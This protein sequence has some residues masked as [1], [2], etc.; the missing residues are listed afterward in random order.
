M[1]RYTVLQNTMTQEDLLGFV[2]IE[3]DGATPTTEDLTWL[4]EVGAWEEFKAN[5]SKGEESEETSLPEDITEWL[6]KLNMFIA[7]N[8]SA[9][10][11]KTTKKFRKMGER[12][13]TLGLVPCFDKDAHEMEETQMYEKKEEY[14]ENTGQA[15]W[16]DDVPYEVRQRTLVKIYFMAISILGFM[17]SMMGLQFTM[18]NSTVVP[19]L[20]R[21][22]QGISISFVPP[23]DSKEE[24]K[25]V[26]GR[27]VLNEETTVIQGE[28]TTADVYVYYNVPLSDEI[29]RYTQDICKVYGVNYAHVL[30][31]MKQESNYMPTAVSPI[32]GNGS[33]DWGIM[34]INSGNHNWL[35]VELG[36]T[37]WL[38]LRHGYVW[39]PNAYYH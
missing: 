24:W 19:Y 26:S 4:K 37:D 8:W 5:R 20:E 2:E 13:L 7:L 29:Q 9:G 38:D 36:I 12:S 30:A 21:D 16:H 35:E 10:D 34:Q 32:N 23:D 18:L 1:G 25:I 27:S 11:L 31:T 3:I 22:G 15:D 6:E 33:Q 17:F 14:P 28:E 39:Q